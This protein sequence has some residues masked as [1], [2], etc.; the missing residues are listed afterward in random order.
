MPVA[1]RPIQDSDLPHVYAL[2]RECYRINPALVYG[3][4]GDLDWWRSI[5]GEPNALDRSEVWVDDM[6]AV[7]AFA[8]P[9]FGRVDVIVRPDMAILNDAVLAWAE[10]DRR[11]TATREQR[12][13]LTLGAWSYTRDRERNAALTRRGY[14]RTDEF[15]YFRRRF[16]A[17]PF[18]DPV[19][20]PG[21]TLRTVE[22]EADYARRVAVH[23]NAFS[24][25]RLT[26]E[27]YRRAVQMPSYR[28][29]LDIVVVAPDNTFA[30]FC[31]VWFDAENQ[32]GVFEP[33]GTHSAHR[34]LGL[35]KAVMYEGLRMLK[36]L[37]AHTAHVN[38]YHDD[39]PAIK[40]YESCG[41][42]EID[43]FHAWEKRL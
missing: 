33:V 11:L 32:I 9:G 26:V 18:P 25:S 23:V 19:L 10:E 3:M 2:M 5:D 17:A 22:G 36:L 24:P 16:I 15:F 8:Y 14:T 42:R 35:G 37:G 38:T 7:V 4:P 40:L 1:N 13:N 31:I 29:D 41:F 34:R 20:P 12:E 43:R 30:A 21:Y 27:M 39:M 28:P 6:G